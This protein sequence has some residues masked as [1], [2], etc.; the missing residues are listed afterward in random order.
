[1]KEERKEKWTKESIRRFR[2]YEIRKICVVCAICGCI[3]VFFS[4]IDRFADLAIRGSTSF[5]CLFFVSL[6]GQHLLL[7]DHFIDG[8]S[9]ELDAGLFGVIDFLHFL[10][11]KR[12][13][14]G[15]DIMLDGLLDV[16]DLPAEPSEKAITRKRSAHIL[17][18]DTG[19]AR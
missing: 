4:F 7:H 11:A 2:R 10:F 16:P 17:T 1:M 8:R 12:H 9:P 15:S 5:L 18:S 14:R 3:S 6:R 13:L 19:K